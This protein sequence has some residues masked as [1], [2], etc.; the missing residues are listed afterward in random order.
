MQL[1]N[2]QWEVDQNKAG[3]IA[4]NSPWFQLKIS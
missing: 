2:D 4:L 1:N 3:H